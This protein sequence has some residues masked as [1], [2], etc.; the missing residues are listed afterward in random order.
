MNKKNLKKRKDRK[1]NR[2]E[3]FYKKKKTKWRRKEE[4]EIKNKEKKRKCKQINLHSEELFI[5]KIA[6]KILIENLNS[7][8]KRETQRCLIRKCFFNI[9]VKCFQIL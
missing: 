4:H 6:V 5:D 1:D 3:T 9:L 2:R 8:V 7:S